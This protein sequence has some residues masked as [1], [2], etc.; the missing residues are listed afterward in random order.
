MEGGGVGG[1]ELGVALRR[2]AGGEGGGEGKKMAKVSTIR[3][4]MEDIG[5]GRE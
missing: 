4:G 5:K 3:E 2:R 1:L